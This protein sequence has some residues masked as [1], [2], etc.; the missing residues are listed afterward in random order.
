MKAAGITYSSAGE[1]IAAGQSSP[2]KCYGFWMNSPGHRKNI[3]NPDFEYIGVGLTRGN[4]TVFIGHRNLQR[5]N[6]VIKNNIFLL[7]HTINSGSIIIYKQGRG[8]LCV[9]SMYTEICN[10]L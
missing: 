3:L 6:N 2:Q 8:A 1:N 9:S 7:T 5:L 4:R 10:Y